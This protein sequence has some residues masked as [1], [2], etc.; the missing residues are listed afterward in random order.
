MKRAPALGLVF[1]VGFSA[2]AFPAGLS[3]YWS[4][5]IVVDPNAAL[6]TDFVDADSEFEVNYTVGGW[7][8][9][10]VAGI[11]D[12]IWDSLDLSFAGRLG[13]FPIDGGIT[14]DPS[15]STFSS[16][17]MLFEVPIGGVMFCTDFS[18]KPG[19]SG[20]AISANYVTNELASDIQ[21]ELG[22][23]SGCDFD[24]S[25]LAVEISFPFCCAAVAAEIDFDC[26][27]FGLARFCIEEVTIENLPWLTVGACVEFQTNSKVLR[28]EP[29]IDLGAVG[30]DFDLYYHLETNAALRT[31]YEP[32]SIQGIAF[33]GIQIACSIG[34]VEF[35]AISYFGDDPKPGILQGTPYWEAY[36]AT[37]S[38]DVC[39]GPFGFDLAVFFSEASTSLFDIAYLTSDVDLHLAES[40]TLCIGVAFDFESGVMDEV[41][42]DFVLS[43]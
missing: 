3:G 38:S 39:C 11:H 35:T 25:G 15:T 23:G 36:Q 18:L 27:G 37:I 9:R 16:L 40:T 31:D 32:L 8:F 33:D 42:V 5:N 13:V 17:G 34:S 26:G 28:M 2:M 29:R 10:S 12:G 22:S 6:W 14:F 30:C 20:L 1:V 43:W 24:F 4:T 19:I 7:T 41:S 21:L